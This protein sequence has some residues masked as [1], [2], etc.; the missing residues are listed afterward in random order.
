MQGI[1][2]NATVAGE[3]STAKAVK[4][5]TGVV[6]IA[7]SACNFHTCAITNGLGKTKGSLYCWGYNE[8]GR[9]GTPISQVLHCI[10]CSCDIYMHV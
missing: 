2:S 7:I 10:M 3:A 9:L 5:G 4:F 1:G 6:P 8:D